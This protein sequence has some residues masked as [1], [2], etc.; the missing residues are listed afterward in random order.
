MVMVLQRKNRLRL[1][2]GGTITIPGDGFIYH[3]FT[4]SGTFDPRGYTGRYF[5][6]LLVGGGGGGGSR[7]PGGG[8]GGGAVVNSNAS[9]SSPQTVTIGSGGAG[10]VGSADVT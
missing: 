2:T 3:T 1:P 5:E 10:G 6:Y 8:G 9:I 7:R 4:S